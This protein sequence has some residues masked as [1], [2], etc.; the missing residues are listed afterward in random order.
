M[1]L[2]AIVSEALARD[3]FPNEDPIGK[4][5]QCGFDSIG[6]WMTIVG[7]VGDV[8][9]DS[10]A[11]PPAPEL[12]MP[13][14]QH[15]YRANE[16]QVVVRTSLDPASLIASVRQR[17]HAMNP[18]VA[19][20][21]TT[22]DAMLSDSVARPRFRMFL[23]GTFAGLA[24]LLAMIGVYGVMSYI[25]TQR[26]SEFGLRV[27]LGAGR[28]DIAGLV[29]GRTTRLAASG[30]AIGLL[31][32]VAASRVMTTMLFGLKPTD[33]MTYIIVLLAVTPVIVLAAAIPAWRATRIDPLTALREE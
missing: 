10:P 3:S 25:I 7:V 28:G 32:S 30:L 5:L 27:A 24:L 6:K 23:I 11:S 14:K 2:V 15:P 1:P 29:L 13:L 12:Y 16:L 9:Q 17:V 31:L 18:E 21:F 26:I 20:K 22:M 4:R 33:P 19:M 8:R